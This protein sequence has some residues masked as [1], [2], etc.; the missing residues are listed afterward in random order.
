V[1]CYEPLDIDN[2]VRLSNE[3]RFPVAA[4]HHAHSA[5]L[6]PDVL[7]DAYGGPPAV[8]IFASFARYKREAYRHSQYA[9]RILADQ[10]IS[11]IMKSDHLAI[12]RTLLHEAQQAHYY[13]LPDHLALASITS[14]PAKTA[15]LDW[16][17]GTIA[18]GL[19]ADI[20]LWDS[21]PLS[22]GATPSQVFIDGIPQLEGM[23]LEKPAALQAAPKTPKF[24]KE[25][26]LAVKVN[27][28][29]IM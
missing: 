19:D 16:R 5:Y 27:N 7:R 28:I 3:F 11:V 18:R 9:P 15:G 20:V 29:N 25:A 24:S 6:V 2:F 12:S 22:L 4:F 8:A 21:H 17:L 1:H 13:G 26:K 14:V 10:N 23:K